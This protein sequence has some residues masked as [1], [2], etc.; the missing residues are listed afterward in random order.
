MRLHNWLMSL[1]VALLLDVCVNI[2]FSDNASQSK[3]WTEIDCSQQSRTPVQSDTSK[4]F[5]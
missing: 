3:L 2:F 1:N 5:N 4:L